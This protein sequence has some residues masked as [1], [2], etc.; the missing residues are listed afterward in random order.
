MAVIGSSSYTLLQLYV[1]FP[2]N[3][4]LESE[5]VYFARSR[6]PGQTRLFEIDALLA[7]VTAKAQRWGYSAS[8]G[9]YS[10]FLSLPAQILVVLPSSGAKESMCETHST[11]RTYIF[12][13]PLAHINF[14]EET[15]T[16]SV[17]VTCLSCSQSLQPEGG[18]AMS[19]QP[20]SHVY[21]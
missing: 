6:N 18:T 7:P 10:I 13:F 3:H 17:W 5:L 19:G 12:P 20:E 21:S 11:I 4:L 15:P 9:T 16:G 14:Q 2:Q 1:W 8:S